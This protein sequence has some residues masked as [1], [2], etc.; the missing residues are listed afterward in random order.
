MHF[1]PLLG[2]GIHG[3]GEKRDAVRPKIQKVPV[4]TFL[5]KKNGG[6]WVYILKKV[7]QNVDLDRG[8]DSSIPCKTSSERR[9]AALGPTVQQ[10]A[11]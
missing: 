2:P 11:S 5:N 4:P 7:T 6:L 1:L 8:P 3:H 10:V 9:V